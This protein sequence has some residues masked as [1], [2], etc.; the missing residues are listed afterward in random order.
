MAGRA[1][2]QLYVNTEEETKTGPEKMKDHKNHSS[3]D[4][5]TENPQNADNNVPQEPFSF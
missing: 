1:E 3:S 2:V 4:R 5:R